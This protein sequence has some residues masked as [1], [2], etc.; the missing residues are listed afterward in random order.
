MQFLP[1]GLGPRMCIGMRLA[2]LEMKIALAHLV[3]TFRFLK[4]EETD[5][6]LKLKKLGLLQ[7][8]NGIKLKLERRM[9]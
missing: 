4:C 2:M 8:I 7:S 5:V 3:R 1:F 9:P 6:P